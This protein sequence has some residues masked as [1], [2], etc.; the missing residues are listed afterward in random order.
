MFEKEKFA[1]HDANAIAAGRI[2]GVNPLEEI[3]RRCIRIIGTVEK[4]TMGGCVI[5]RLFIYFLFSISCAVLYLEFNSN[6]LSVVLMKQL[7]LCIQLSP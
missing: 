1:E 2:P 4:N 5:C 6:I 7:C 3:T